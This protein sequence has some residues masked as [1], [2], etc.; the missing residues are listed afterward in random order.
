MR[1]KPVKWKPLFAILLGLLII[2]VLSYTQATP[3]GG[4][5]V[6][7]LDE[8]G[9]ALTDY[10]KVYYT[11]WTFEKNGSIKTLQRG[12][13]EKNFIFSGNTIKIPS[14]PLNQAKNTAARIGSKTA[15][16]GIDVWIV[17]NGKVYT[18]PP[19][20]FET[21][22]TKTLLPENIKI[23]INMTEAV[24]KDL[25]ELK[26]APPKSSL[27]PTA[28]DIY[29]TWK[30]ESQKSYTNVKI[31]ILIIKNN[32]SSDIHGSA[33]LGVI[34]QKYW[35]P[36]VTVAFGD[37]ISKKVKFDPSSIEV[38]ILGRSTTDYYAGG[39]YVT[40]PD[41]SWGYVWIR[42]TVHYIYQKEYLCTAWCHPTGNERYFAKI[43]GF[44]V[45]RVGERVKHIESG[46]TLGRPPYNFPSSWMEKSEGITV[47]INESVSLCEFY[48]RIYAGSDGYSFGVGV[49]VGAILDALADGSLPSWFNVITVGFSTGDHSSY[50]ML[51]GVDNKGPP[52][53]V[54]FHAMESNY[55]LRIPV[56]HWYGTSYED[57][58][59]PIGLYVEAGYSEYP[60]PGDPSP[61]PCF[62][63]RC[64]NY[65]N[66]ENG[67]S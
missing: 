17:K 4:A 46:S 61:V 22:L 33:Y 18:L 63:G 44:T 3:I 29:Y 5:K 34:V 7:L 38:K 13:L 41:R 67:K 55:K 20:S 40:V 57:V 65:E 36:D 9:K 28:H 47:G 11:V 51:G 59:V 6:I 60:S 43:D 45:D 10:G 1:V 31:P 64:P 21:K 58:N 56:H 26:T 25:K 19:E 16:I 66:P 30:T 62:K 37:E 54:T 27:Q 14:T 42:G 52:T 50:V 2:G 35:G 48:D 23:K 24:I 53:P 49:P 8:N 12:M 15:F 32:V 39:Y